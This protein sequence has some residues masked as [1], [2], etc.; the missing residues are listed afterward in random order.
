MLQIFIAA[1]VSVVLATSVLACPGGDCPDGQCPLSKK[2]NLDADRAAKLDA[3]QV[4]F[5]QDR[6]AMKAA[7][8]AKL[9]EILTPEE[10]MKLEA[11]HGHHGHDHKGG[12]HGDA[13]KKCD[14]HAKKD[15]AKKSPL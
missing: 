12:H 4:K 3:L 1:L 14:E 13:P 15:A 10:L 7:H 8:Q 11:E 9:A 5:K 6:D 2:L